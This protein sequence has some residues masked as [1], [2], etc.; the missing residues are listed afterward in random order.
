MAFWNSL[1]NFAIL[2]FF[3]RCV[4][5]EAGTITCFKRE[6][7]ASYETKKNCE[8]RVFESSDEMAT[9][10]AEFISQVSEIS[11]KE[12]GYFAIAL[13]GGPLTRHMR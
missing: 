2:L 10:L 4:R 13:S 8:I 11:V 9:D 3:N 12:R 1:L 7:M 5:L 6:I